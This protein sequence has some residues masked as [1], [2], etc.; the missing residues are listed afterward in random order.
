MIDTFKSTVNNI[1][2]FLSLNKRLQLSYQGQLVNLESQ[3]PIKFD[4]DNVYC[5]ATSRGSYVF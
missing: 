1:F 4:R 5:L 2:Y 3:K